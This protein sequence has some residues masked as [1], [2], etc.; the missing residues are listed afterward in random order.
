MDLIVFE[1]KV[2]SNEKGSMRNVNVFLASFAPV[3]DP[4]PMVRASDEE[5]D[6]EEEEEEEDEDEE[7]FF[8]G[9]RSA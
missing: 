4:D 1:S 3:P 9:I 7:T 6:D 2:K 5:E 8:L